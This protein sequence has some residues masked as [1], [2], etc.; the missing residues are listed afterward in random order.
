[1]SH[2]VITY[3]WGSEADEGTLQAACVGHHRRALRIERPVW[4]FGDQPDPS[5]PSRRGATLD[6][7]AVHPGRQHAVGC[8]TAPQSRG[9]TG[10]PVRPR[11][12]P[13]TPFTSSSPAAP[14][15]RRHRLVRP[16]RSCRWRRLPR[17]APRR[18]LRRRA[19]LASGHQRRRGPHL[20][21]G[22][23][24]FLLS[25]SEL[26]WP[27]RPRR[28]RVP[29]APPADRPR[30]AGARRVGRRWTP[31]AGRVLGSDGVAH[32]SARRAAARGGRRSSRGVSDG[33]VADRRLLRPHAAF[34]YADADILGR[35]RAR[36]RR[37]RADRRVAD[38][39][40][41]RRCARARR[42]GQD[43]GDPRAGSHRRHRLAPLRLA[44]VLAT[45]G[46]SPRRLARSASSACGTCTPIRST[47]RPA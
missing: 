20:G 25:G 34:R 23:D 2:D 38:G 1:M 39:A 13:V 17:L 35:R 15:T 8:R 11:H 28:P 44:A 29:A 7:D 42:P 36:L 24:R 19:Q 14:L 33:G 22:A 5:R 21:R 30:V 16:W 46:S 4:Q 12:V 3:N 47:W 18:A 41:R 6:A 45:P 9:R 26:G 32:L 31:G 43:S 40:R 27:R 37:L 10:R